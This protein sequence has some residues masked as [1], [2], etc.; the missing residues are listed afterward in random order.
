MVDRA[1]IERLLCMLKGYLQDLRSVQ[2]ISFSEYLGDIR[3]QRFVERT[4]QIA[5]E[6]CLDIGNHI[7]S[8]EGFRE[9]EDNRDIFRI[10]GEKGL[11]HPQLQKRLEDMASFRNLIVHSYGKI[12]HEIVFSILKKRLNDIDEFMGCVIEL[13]TSKQ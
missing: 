9:P 6:A 7:I 3:T 10:L 4:L 1:V 12:D 2:D 5:I 11:I 13:L 8:E